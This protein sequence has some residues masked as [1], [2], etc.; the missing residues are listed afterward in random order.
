MLAFHAPVDG[1]KAAELRRLLTGPKD[2]VEKAIKVWGE[3]GQRPRGMCGG[4]GQVESLARGQFHSHL[5]SIEVVE[6][7]GL[8]STM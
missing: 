8:S 2:A 5:N 4:G 6:Y 3:G 7:G 1:P